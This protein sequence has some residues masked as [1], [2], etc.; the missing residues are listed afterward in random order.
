M[1]RNLVYG[2]DAVGLWHGAAGIVAAKN[3]LGAFENLRQRY[4]SPYGN[5]GGAARDP[6]AGLHKLDDIA[7]IQYIHIGG[8]C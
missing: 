4:R 7:R 3:A 1:I 5:P 2:F 6:V 8:A